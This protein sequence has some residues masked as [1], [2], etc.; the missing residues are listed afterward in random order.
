MRCG[1][2]PNTSQSRTT[3]HLHTHRWGSWLLLL[4]LHEAAKQQIAD[5]SLGDE[6]AADHQVAAATRGC[7]I[8]TSHGGV[9]RSRRRRGGLP[10]G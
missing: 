8:A 5:G 3:D 7:V 2:A 6:A 4:Q 1:S 9:T 10:R